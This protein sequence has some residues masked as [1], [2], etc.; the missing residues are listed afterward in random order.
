MPNNHIKSFASLTGTL[1]RDA[2]RAPYVNRYA[3]EL[4]EY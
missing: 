2:D 3:S 1:R 4:N